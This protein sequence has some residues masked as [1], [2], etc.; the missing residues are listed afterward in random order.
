MQEF[1][2]KNQNGFKFSGVGSE[3]RKVFSATSLNVI[4]VFETSAQAVEAF[5]RPMLATPAPVEA[6]P[7]IEAAPTEDSEKRDF[8]LLSLTPE[9]NETAG[10][11]DPEAE[12]EV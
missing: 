8:G 1:A 12:S 3:F 2:G 10:E 6:A 9:L 11:T 5:L 7:I 4:D